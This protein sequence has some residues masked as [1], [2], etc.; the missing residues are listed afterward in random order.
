MA[1]ILAKETRIHTRV[2]KQDGILLNIIVET[3]NKGDVKN[4]IAGIHKSDPVVKAVHGD[5][6]NIILSQEMGV[7]HDYK[8]KGFQKMIF[9]PKGMNAYRI[10][11]TLANH[12]MVS[13]VDDDGKTFGKRKINDLSRDQIARL[14]FEAYKN[15][16]LIK[17]EK[18]EI[19]KETVKDEKEREEAGAIMGDIAE[20][21]QL[22][23]F[24]EYIK[25]ESRL[26]P[27]GSSGVEAKL[28]IAGQKESEVWSSGAP[29]MKMLVTKNKKASSLEFKKF[30][31]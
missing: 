16:E 8:N 11:E 24:K 28:K 5:L 12:F 3:F 30:N 23:L 15:S 9:D 19:V 13:K 2:L 31:K 25:S 4:T 22:I 10:N 21:Q 27:A 6:Q 17:A 18:E 20:A 7:T 14:V 26:H 1:K 29:S